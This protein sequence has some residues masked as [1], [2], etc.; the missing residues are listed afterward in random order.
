MATIAELDVP[1]SGFVLDETL[2]SVPEARFEVER[3]VS[4]DHSMRLFWATGEVDER[5]E[6]IRNDP[7]VVSATVLSEFGDDRLYWVEWVDGVDLPTDLFVDT[8]AT[9]LEAIASANHWE[10]QVFFPERAVLSG[11]YHRCRERGVDLE[12]RNAYDLSDVRYGRF[13]LTP[14]QRETLV[15]AYDRGYYDVP[16][17]VTTEELGAEFGISHQAVSDRL[18]RGHRALVEHV[19][20]DGRRE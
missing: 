3:V 17:R 9:V 7:T 20:M 16:H 5:S 6:A 2:S 18:R 13:G 14:E 4:D 1:A 10:L 15:A 12:L 19:L 11:L 8:D